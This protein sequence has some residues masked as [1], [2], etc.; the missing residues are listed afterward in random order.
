[1]SRSTLHIGEFIFNLKN[2]NCEDKGFPME[3]SFY[4]NP[5]IP[6]N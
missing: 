3:V 5:N 4:Q 6:N 1:M 2:Y